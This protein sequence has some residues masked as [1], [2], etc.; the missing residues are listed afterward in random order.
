MKTLSARF[1]LIL[2]ILGLVG[3][4]GS[5]ATR[6]E[7]P[8]QTPE[9]T[10]LP[11]PDIHYEATIQRGPDYI[12][13]LRA[14]P[15][16]EQPSV[17]EGKSQRGDQRELASKGFVRIGN[18]RYP[19]DD[20]ESVAAAIDLG[21][22][23]GADQI[24]IYHEQPTQDQP[25]SLLAAYYVRFKLLF[26][27]TFRNLTAEEREQLQLDGGVQIGS[28]VGQTPASQ[29]NLMA[30]DYVIAVDGKAVVDRQQFQQML[31]HEAGHPVTL[32]IIRN[33]KRSDRVVRLGALPPLIK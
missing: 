4:C 11:E 18:G 32:K 7:Q 25:G 8:L 9:V 6:Y 2:A 24:W 30:G 16:P 27:A 33:Q 13:A 5:V 12:D 15:A 26:G 22:R 1:I 28:V 3:G 29:A 19:M 17:I 31:K 14:E 20:E 10:P 21:R 23:V